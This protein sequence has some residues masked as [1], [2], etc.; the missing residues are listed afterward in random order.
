MEKMLITIEVRHSSRSV[1]PYTNRELEYQE[2]GLLS[3]S[4]NP[5]PTTNASSA[6][7]IA[8]K[9]ACLKPGMRSTAGTVTMNAMNTAFRIATPAELPA[10]LNVFVIP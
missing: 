7:I 5:I 2:E 6:M 9:K 4:L 8:T 3:L 1:T 10:C